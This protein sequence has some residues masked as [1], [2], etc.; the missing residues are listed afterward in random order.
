MNPHIWWYLSRAS[1]IVAWAMLTVSVLWGIVLATD[2]FPKWRRTAWI[3]DMHRWLAGLTI[4]FIAGHVVTLLFDSFAHFGVRDV[5]VPLAST[6]RPT[7]IALGIVALWLLLAVEA[8]ALA[9]RRL[10][11]RWWRDVHIASYFVFW[12]VNIHAALAGTDTSRPLSAVAATAALAVVVFA[13]SY[14]TL[15]RDLPKR[16]AAHA[17]RRPSALPTGVESDAAGTR[18]R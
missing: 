8:T 1:G 14:R 2:L 7:A 17:M 4:F 5:L 6:W 12:A 9:R 18:V 3:L 15:S 11:R 16:R 10:S 13:A